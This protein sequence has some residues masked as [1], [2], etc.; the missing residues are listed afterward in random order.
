VIRAVLDANIFVSGFPARAGVLAELIDRWRAGSYGL[1]VSQHILD[2]VAGAWTKP[3]WR[4]RFSEAQ[5]ERA[6]LLRAEAELTP[7]TVPV[8]D[9]ASHPEDDL[10]L[11]AAVSV[12]VDYLA[13]G[14]KKLQALGRYGGVSILS[15]HA[16]FAILTP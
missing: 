6:L 13:T 3:Y 14:D 16:F 15:P 5:V 4:A 1:V 10:V 12:A 2:E 9:V 11:S 8:V 7:L